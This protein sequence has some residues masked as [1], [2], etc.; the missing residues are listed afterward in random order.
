MAKKDEPEVQGTDETT[1]D[2]NAGADAIQGTV[3]D[4]DTADAPDDVKE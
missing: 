3:A 2:T 1:V 4:A